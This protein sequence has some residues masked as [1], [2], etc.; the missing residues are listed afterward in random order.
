MLDGEP[1]LGFAPVRVDMTEDG[2]KLSKESRVNYSKLVTIEHNVKVFIGSI[3]T[4][5]WRIRGS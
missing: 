2:E 1:K 5:G 4:V 3:V